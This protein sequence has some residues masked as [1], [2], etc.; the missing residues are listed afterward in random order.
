LA[1]TDTGIAGDGSTAPTS[2]TSG[3]IQSPNYGDIN[4]VTLGTPANVTATPQGTAGSTT[5][6][7]KVDAISVSGGHTPAS[8]AATTTT[9]NAT[10]T[11]ANSV[12]VTWSPVPGAVSYNIYRTAAGGTPSTTGKIGS[13]PALAGTTLYSFTD[14]G[15]AGDS[16]TAPTTNTTGGITF[17]GGSL[18]PAGSTGLGL[19]NYIATENGA[20]NAIACSAGSGPTL[21]TGLIVYVALAHTL[22]G[23]TSITFAYNGGSAIAIKS[24]FN[25][26]NNIATAYAATGIIG[27]IYNGTIWLDLSQ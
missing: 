8:S 5:V 17:N 2:N 4:V 18:S 15:L 3:I 7:Y 22:A 1:F 14:T 27:L 19:A 25:T 11:S 16:S 23:S 13:V 24:H 20:N 10:L 12:L 26:A 6:T 21:A 9:A